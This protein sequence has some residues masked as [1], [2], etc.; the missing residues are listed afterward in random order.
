VQGAML[1]H[2]FQG[3]RTAEYSLVGRGKKKTETKRRKHFVIKVLIS[4]QQL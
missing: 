4:F 2:I 1:E 3:E